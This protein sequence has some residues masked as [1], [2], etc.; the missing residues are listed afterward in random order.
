MVDHDPAAGSG[1][2][3]RRVDLGERRDWITFTAPLKRR[4]QGAMGRRSRWPMPRAWVTASTCTIGC[5]RAIVPR[6]VHLDRRARRRRPPDQGREV[7]FSTSESSEGAPRLFENLTRNTV[8]SRQVRLPPPYLRFHEAPRHRIVL[9]AARSCGGRLARGD[10]R[11]DARCAPGRA[12]A[13]A[14]F[15][16]IPTATSTPPSRSLTR[17]R[18][19]ETSHEGWTAITRMYTKKPRG[20]DGRAGFEWR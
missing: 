14:V 9:A 18:A 8:G 7:G 11:G 3:E 12:R 19:R 6:V 15:G 13:R 2:P 17:A 16:A 5:V 20:R 4:R 1:Q 10:R